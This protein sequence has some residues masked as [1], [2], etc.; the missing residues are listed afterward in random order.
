VETGSWYADAVLWADSRGIIQGYGNTL[1]GS[2]DP[3]TREQLVVFLY[4]YSMIKGRDISASSDL[5]GF[6]DSDQISDYAMEAM[7]WAVAL[8]NAPACQDTILEL[9]R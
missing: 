6:T 5:S 4:R 3:I 1:F 8:Y 7:K 2:N 9:L